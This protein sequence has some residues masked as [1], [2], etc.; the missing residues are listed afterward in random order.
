MTI[1]LP[2]KRASLN[3]VQNPLHR[4]ALAQGRRHHHMGKAAYHHQQTLQIAK[5]MTLPRKP[6]K[7]SLLPRQ[8]NLRRPLFGQLPKLIGHQAQVQGH[9]VNH[10]LPHANRGARRQ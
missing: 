4:K 6:Q 7:A 8:P 5:R 10:P 1:A 3:Q 2:F 9:M